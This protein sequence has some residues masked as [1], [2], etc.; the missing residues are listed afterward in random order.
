MCACSS[1]SGASPGSCPACG[2]RARS[3]STWSAID[4][5]A[6]G[7]TALGEL[8]PAP[9]FDLEQAARGRGARTT[10]LTLMYT[11]GTTG[12]PKGV[13]YNHRAV[14]AA[15]AGFDSAVP[16]T[17]WLHAV[18]FIPFAHAGQRAIGHYRS[19]L[20]GS[21]TTFCPDPAAL[22][23]AIAD[24]RPSVLFAPPA[25]WQRLAA[26]A[27]AAMADDPAARAAHARALASVRRG[28][29]ASAVAG[30]RRGARAARPRP[31]RRSRS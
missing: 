30:A 23:A 18:A 5:D 9:G 21:T 15:F 12:A 11:S 25:I 2:A 28:E 16:A 27:H 13:V 19:L 29:A 7:V 17:D 14:L 4:G 6:P 20:H 22:P 10:A 1:R 31:A 24:A 3:S 8:S 26:G